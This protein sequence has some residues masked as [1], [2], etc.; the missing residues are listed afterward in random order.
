MG[1]KLRAETATPAW[2]G[3]RRPN[4]MARMDPYVMEKHPSRTK[5]RAGA[6]GNRACW[7]PSSGLL[8]L[9]SGSAHHTLGLTLFA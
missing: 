7:E 6:R 3:G 9:T 1:R 2:P 4:G 8:P 5:A